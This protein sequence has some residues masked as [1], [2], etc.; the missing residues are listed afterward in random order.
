MFARLT[1]V[2]IKPEK[3]VEFLNLANAEIRPLVTR[4][5][6][7][8]EVVALISDTDP[9][10]AVSLVLW[11]NRQNAERFYASDE[12]R[13]WIERIGPYLREAPT[14]KTYDVG[15]STYHRISASRAA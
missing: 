6:G 10:V 2:T 1:E 8:M 7:S 14:F 11:D 13:Q 15:T 12:F 3:R 4:Q 5:P 9:N